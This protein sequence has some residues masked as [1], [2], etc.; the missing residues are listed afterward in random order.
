MKYFLS[1]TTTLCLFLGIFSG[2]N[3]VLNTITFTT[4]GKP[5][6]CIFIESS[7]YHT[8]ANSHYDSSSSRIHLWDHET[9]TILETFSNY[10]N[11]IVSPNGTY[12]MLSFYYSA[13]LLYSIP[14]KTSIPVIH[15]PAKSNPDK[16]K[17][18]FNVKVSPDSRYITYVLT[19]PTGNKKKLLKYTPG[20]NTIPE[21]SVKEWG[22]I[23]DLSFCQFHDDNQYIVY[24]T[25]QNKLVQKNLDDHSKSSFQL[26]NVP[27][28]YVEYDNSLIWL[29]HGRSGLLCK[30]QEDSLKTI[31]EISYSGM[32][33]KPAFASIPSKK[34]IC[35]QTG[36]CE[37][38]ILDE[39]DGSIKSYEQKGQL[40]Q[41][42]VNKI[43]SYL[44][45]QCKNKLSVYDLSKSNAFTTSE[46]EIDPN[47][48]IKS[49]TFITDVLLLIQ[50]DS[51]K[52]F[53]LLT[54]ELT[55]LST[56][57]TKNFLENYLKH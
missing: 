31:S 28:I 17:G 52:I 12:L 48:E 50:G 2:Q 46:R 29:P 3:C 38:S 55:N 11:C 42:V 5:K 34:L 13:P 1:V 10:N 20:S 36:P 40:K 53:N 47:M 19:S 54:N 22:T 41:I 43:D 23:R 21:I 49:I 45:A 27:Y 33:Y 6:H 26:V 57:I 9:N 15:N 8:S 30:I 32:G 56:V 37:L 25:N 18:V 7:P 24:L 39:R 35:Y 16:K 4:D 51:I 44:I 14:D